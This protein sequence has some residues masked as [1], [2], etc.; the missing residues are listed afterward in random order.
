M[1]PLAVRTLYTVDNVSHIFLCTLTDF[2]KIISTQDCF[3]GHSSKK[4][5]EDLVHG[6]LVKIVSNPPGSSADVDSFTLSS[7]CV[8]G[9]KPA[10]MQGDPC[11]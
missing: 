11:F 6:P 2:L 1:A 9:K 7:L 3:G 4:R 10:Y 5:I 8:L